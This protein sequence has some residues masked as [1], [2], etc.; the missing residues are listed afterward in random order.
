MPGCALQQPGEGVLLALLVLTSMK[1]M[2]APMRDALH[3]EHSQPELAGWTVIFVVCAGG[4]G[5]AARGG[6]APARRAVR[7]G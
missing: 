1:G 6:G 7:R 2:V 3:M 5:P 4:G